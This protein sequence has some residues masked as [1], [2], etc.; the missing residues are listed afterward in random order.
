[1]YKL[2]VLDLQRRTTAILENAHDIGYDFEENV[3]WQMNFSLPLDDPKNA[4]VE[5][6]QYI[7]FYDGDEHLGMYRIMPKLTSS[8]GIEVRYECDHV[9]SLLMDDVLFE[10]HQLTNIVTREVLVYLLNQQITKHW[11]LGECAFTRYFHY[12]WE[13][14]NGLLGAIFS[15]P[16]PFDVE[17]RWTWDTS[18]YPFVLNLVAAET[19][20]TCRLKEGR[21]LDNFEI[22]ENPNSLINRIYP[23]GSGEG[24]NQL[25]IKKINGGIPYI[26]DAASVNKY[27]RVSYIWA[28][29][30]YT[31]VENLKAS[32]E[33]L[34]KKWK[35][36]IVSW[37]IKAINLLKIVNEEPG[38]RVLAIDAL[39][40]GK[41]VRVETKKYGIVDLRILKI[42]NKNADT[43]PED[44][45]LTIGNL[46]DDIATTQSDIERKI[47]INDCYSQGATNIDKE[48]FADNCDAENPAT[49]TIV[50]DEDVV[51]VNACELW[52]ETKPFRAYSKSTLGGGGSVGSTQ[53]AGQSSS[54]STSTANGDHR[55]R[56]FMNVPDGGNP[57]GLDALLADRFFLAGESDDQAQGIMTKLR[58]S[59][60]EW[61]YTKEAAGSHAH[62]VTVEVPAHNHSV[63]I[64]AHTH[65]IEYGIY[66]NSETADQLIIKI[67][68]VEP[69]QAPDKYQRGKTSY[70]RLNLIPYLAKGEGGVIARNEHTIEIL[71]NCMARIEAKAVNRVFIKSQLGGNY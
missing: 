7:D 32:A 49:M 8:N 71:P 36:P 50:F 66:E 37:K 70:Q 18:V 69:P 23:L 54:T 58:V 60:P 67:D 55:H 5:L 16:K 47:D 64:P 39:K 62:E 44:I 24:V 51:N 43:S 53:A 6:M 65:D 33:S 14:E 56:M 20:P 61:L 29:R 30:R 3:I 19:Q 52:L 42:T 2:F 34:L 27:G 46:T 22:S 10:Y 13:N 35:Q 9:L 11:V 63:E 57:G 41:I 12:A 26:E 38:F 4:K 45:D 28:D 17:Y 59:K 40:V 25:K 15:V 31:I 48:T 68:G 1:M 21:N